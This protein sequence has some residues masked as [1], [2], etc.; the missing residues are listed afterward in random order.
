VAEDRR[1]FGCGWNIAGQCGV[2][3]RE[4][5]I[6][7]PREIS[8]LRGEEIVLMASGAM[9]GHFVTSNREFW[10]VGSNAFG[11]CG[12]NSFEDVR[13]PIRLSLP[14]NHEPVR[15]LA[16]GDFFTI[17]VLGEI[18]SYSWGRNIHCQAGLLRSNCVPKPEICLALNRRCEDIIFMVC[19]GDHTAVLSTDGTVYQF[20]SNAAKQFGQYLTTERTPA[21]TKIS[22]TGTVKHLAASGNVTTALDSDGNLYIWGARHTLHNG[23]RTGLQE[24]PEVVWRCEEKDV[25][26]LRM[27]RN[28][29]H[30]LTRSGYLYTWVF[31]HWKSAPSPFL[32]KQYWSYY[33]N[34]QLANSKL[35]DDGTEMAVLHTDSYCSEQIS[36]LN[37]QETQI[38]D[39]G[40]AFTESD[41]T[42]TET[43]EDVRPFWLDETSSEDGDP[44]PFPARPPLPVQN[45]NLNHDSGEQ[46]SASDSEQSNQ[47]SDTEEPRI[48]AFSSHGSEELALPH[49]AKLPISPWKSY[50]VGVDAVKDVLCGAFTTQLLLYGNR[51]SSEFSPLALRPVE[52]FADTDLLLS[53]GTIQKV[54]KFFIK[55]RCPA[56]LAKPTRKLLKTATPSLIRLVIKYLYYE[57]S[58]VSDISDENLVELKSLLRALNMKKCE[59]RSSIQS[60]IASRGHSAMRMDVPRSVVDFSIRQFK[61]QMRVLYETQSGTDFQ[62][63]ASLSVN[64]GPQGV[65]D[66][67]LG[68]DSGNQAY[69]AVHR[70]IL[71]ARCP[72]FESLFR[73]NFSEHLSG[74][75][76]LECTHHTLDHFLRY[77]YYDY[78]NF[79]IQSAIW[80]LQ[81]SNLM[82]VDRLT[83]QPLRLACISILRRSGHRNEL[84]KILESI[85]P[86]LDPY[87][88]GREL[89]GFLSRPS[90]SSSSAHPADLASNT[91]EMEDVASDPPGFSRTGNVA[92][93]KRRRKRRSDALGSAGPE[94]APSDTPEST[95]PI[96]ASPSQDPPSTP[97]QTKAAET[98][99]SSEGCPLASHL[100]QI[101]LVCRPLLDQL[102]N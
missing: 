92:S 100:T 28:H 42:D 39:L 82:F 95:N 9:H 88:E 24:H 36:K 8:V 73:S 21:L 23:T 38:D 5:C 64:D 61:Q 81:N 13:K 60:E 80:I 56:L 25:R 30:L 46:D 26:L 44:P 2:G 54:H 53:D 69:I 65:K 89:P 70:A 48:G 52:Y 91:V 79:S 71:A 45:Q 90:P 40:L 35:A 47:G 67:E 14:M 66:E 62:I 63:A 1:A 84:K 51:F 11:Q 15:L 16:C 33:S 20:G 99:T 3:S 22:L 17:V 85:D 41:E 7:V 83:R 43:V 49:R 34:L 50:Y 97:P 68:T 75:I 72:F 59:L 98:A 58:I 12:N 10:S 101:S 6:K 18:Y 94:L 77:I 74:S 87:E 32:T 57:Y 86:T 37:E 96:D 102:S 76:T 29:L 93:T 31:A 4:E 19:G 27:G 78:T 55:I